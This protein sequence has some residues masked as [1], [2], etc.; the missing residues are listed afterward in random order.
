MFEEHEENKPLNSPKNEFTCWTCVE[1]HTGGW[2]M[3][4]WSCGEDCAVLH[5]GSVDIDWRCRS[6]CGSSA[7]PGST[8][9]RSTHTYATAKTPVRSRCWT[10]GQRPGSR[11]RFTTVSGTIMGLTGTGHI[12]EKVRRAPVLQPA[13]RHWRPSCKTCVCRCTGMQLIASI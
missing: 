7:C 8:P 2:W 3:L 9:G 6:E 1:L 12:T 5:L 11:S 10:R 13:A 4:Q